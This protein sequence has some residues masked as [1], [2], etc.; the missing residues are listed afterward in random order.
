M[1]TFE[2]S[3][4][5]GDE[6]ISFDEDVEVT[7][8]FLSRSGEGVGEGIFLGSGKDLGTSHLIEPTCFAEYALD[9]V[10]T[11]MHGGFEPDEVVGGVI[12]DI[13]N[14]V[15]ALPLDA[16]E[17]TRTVEG[18]TDYFMAFEAAKIPHTRILISSHAIIA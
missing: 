3:F 12:E 7:A 9:G 2:L 16:V 5:A 17:V 18:S 6:L 8:G 14:D 1:F 11:A 4:K 13:G 15:M 10:V